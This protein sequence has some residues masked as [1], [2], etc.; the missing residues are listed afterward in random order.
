MWQVWRKPQSIVWQCT[1]FCTCNS[2]RTLLYMLMESCGL[3]E[4][5]RRSCS[6]SV[7]ISRQT[8]DWLQSKEVS[9]V[10]LDL[11]DSS[12][13]FGWLTPSSSSRL[14]GTSTSRQQ[15]CGAGVR[16]ERCVFAGMAWWWSDY[17][18]EKMW[19]L[20]N[21][22]CC[23]NGVCLHRILAW[24]FAVRTLVFQCNLIGSLGR[25]KPCKTVTG[26][27]FGTFSIF[28]FSWECHPNYCEAG[29][30]PKVL[31][32]VPRCV[33]QPRSVKPL[34]RWP[35]PRIAMPRIAQWITAWRP[36]R[37]AWRELRSS[38]MIWWQGCWHGWWHGWWHGCGMDG[39]F[40]WS[41]T[42]FS[43]VLAFGFSRLRKTGVEN[44]TL[45]FQLLG[46]NN[47]GAQ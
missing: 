7:S 25:T 47:N 28:P 9:L 29:Q 46:K 2:S 6:C 45:G 14:L 33:P 5:T 13:W 40:W 23:T 19:H 3:Q 15:E 36:K 8:T 22:F 32:G 18:G 34:S 39:W 35:M 42:V 43:A 37:S 1:C 44:D 41:G 10:W 27:W 31:K 30:W 17:M 21:T 26:W 12:R 38:E 16:C 4:V 11:L 24:P 20:L